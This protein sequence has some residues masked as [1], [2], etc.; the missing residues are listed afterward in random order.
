MKY[1]KIISNQIV[2]ISKEEFHFLKE[3][4]ERYFGKSVIY[5]EDYLNCVTILPFQN[6]RFGIVSEHDLHLMKT[7]EIDQLRKDIEINQMLES[8]KDFN[9][10]QMAN[11]FYSKLVPDE[12][13][14]KHSPNQ[15]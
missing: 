8:I 11:G 4:D 3:R 6:I 1:Q 2:E 7:R 5:S 10:E 14:E 9:K 12:F 15:Q 13:M